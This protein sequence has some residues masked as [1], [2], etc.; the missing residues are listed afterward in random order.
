MTAKEKLL[1]MLAGEKV[2][3]LINEW[4]PFQMMVDPMMIYTTSAAPGEDGVPKDVWGVGYIDEE[5]QPARM[6]L[7][8]EGYIVCPDITEWKDTVKAP[9]LANMEWDF[10]AVKAQ[11]DA[12]RANG[13]LAM[14]FTPVGIFELL[15]NLMG[16]EDCLVNFLLEPE[17]MEE[18]IEYLTEFRMTY[19]KLLV[20][21]VRPDVVLF[22]DDWGAKDSMFMSPEVWREFLKPAYA[23]IYGYLKSEGII[24]MHHADSHLEPI[25]EDMEEIGIDIWQGVLPQNDIV[26]MQKRL[27]GKMILMGGVDAG[28]IDHKD[29]DPEI[30]RKEV[31]RTCEEYLPGGM[32]IP[33]LTYGGPG[34]IFPGVDETIQDELSKIDAQMCQ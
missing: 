14:T 6:P 11:R 13:K 19:F 10:S 28:V 18:L 2:E 25:V 23:K 12:A 4:E 31:R 32:F 24:T 16:F 17:A 15:H 3:G 27:K 7:E 1:A 20:E 5:D 26:A 9:D 22:H 33:C 21:N 29:I 8:A 34:G 30:I